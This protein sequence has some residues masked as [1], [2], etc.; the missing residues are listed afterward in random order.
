MFSMNKHISQHLKPIEELGKI[1]YG[2]FK[3]TYVKSES[4]AGDAKEESGD[5]DDEE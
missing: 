4:G 1:D 5:D 2:D 3:S